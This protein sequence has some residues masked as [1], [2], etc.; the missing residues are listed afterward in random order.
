MPKLL[1]RAVRLTLALVVAGGLGIGAR[2]ASAG[3]I[4]PNCSHQAPY[5]SCTAA[6]QCDAPCQ[7]YFGPEA[8]GYCTR[9]CCICAI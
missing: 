9:G 2:T 6:S 3:A 1:D 7:D 5:Q 8:Q 4:P